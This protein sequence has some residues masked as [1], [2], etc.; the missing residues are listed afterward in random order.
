LHIQAKGWQII[1]V[2]IDEHDNSI[3]AHTMNIDK[4]LEWCKN[5]DWGKGA[6]VFSANGATYI[7]GL[8]ERYQCNDGTVISNH[9]S[10][11]ADY[12]TLRNWAGY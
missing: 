2:T 12:T 7:G 6:Y 5:H 1:A 9:V 11:H 8:L 10:L 4:L 3:G